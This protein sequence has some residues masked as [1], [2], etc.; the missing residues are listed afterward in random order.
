MDQR[1]SWSP[2]TRGAFLVL[3]AVF[4]ILWF[5]QLDIRH[6][7]ASDEGRYAEMAREMFVTHDWVT[8]RYN[9]Y[10]YFEKPPLQTWMTALAYAGFGVGD[11]QA[12]LWTALTG[13][14]AVF[15]IGFTGA[16]VFN[17]AAGF[18]A[19]VALAASPYWNLLGHFNTLD[20]GLSF[21]MTV[22]LCSL[23]LAQRPGISTGAVRGWMWLCW[24]SM[25][26]AV[27]SKG[28]I[29]IVLPGAVLVLYSLIA[30]DGGV[31][32]RLYLISGLLIF[33]AIT[34]PWF[35]LVQERNPEFFDFFFIN[36]HFRRFLTPDHH[37]L[38]PI[39]YFVPVL[40]VGFLPWLSVVGQS[41]WQALKLPRQ[42]NHFSPVILICVWTVFIFVF[43][44][45]SKSKLLSYTLPIAP[46]IAMLIGL[47]LPTLNRD[48][49]RRHLIGYAVFIV[50]AMVG[51]VYLSNLGD[52]RT[53][54]VLY[55]GF[56][57]WVWIALAVGLV[58]IGLAALIN[59][60]RLNAAPAK[61]ILTFAAAWFLIAGIAGNAHEIFG[62]SSS[63]VLLAPAVKAELARLPADT[64]FYSV[65]VLD[66]TM[67]FYVDHTMI[68]VQHQD[69]L[70][71]GIGVEPQKWVPTV[72]E[73]K[74][75]WLA[76]KT[77]MALLP[78]RLYKDFRAEGLPMK[79]I[80]RD[81]RRVIVSKPDAAAPVDTTP[82]ETKPVS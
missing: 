54:N 66:H 60:S 77:A 51:A 79:E 20:M 18:F 52:A 75:R 7:I 42:P 4:T 6:L 21:M 78:P 5:G 1:N 3:L 31:W 71:F 82:A 55:R 43:F 11:W 46:S 61:A 67:P 64:P 50:A 16:R 63:G 56:Q 72:D 28:L 44:S 40:I 25:A 49:M 48:Q 76:D 35:L 65:D 29:G 53:P 9:G 69:E 19:A 45:V 57:V 32:R 33:F 15:V 26:L 47:Y 59:R 10:K 34:T 13:F 22:T 24:A 62:R 38:G 27:L 58:V 41:A 37:R 80:A 2:L 36:E 30:R 17:P 70:A 39:Y 8:L 68:M 73:W 23:L 81:E 14:G 74:K 12:R